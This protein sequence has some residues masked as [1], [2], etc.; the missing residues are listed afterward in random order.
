MLSAAGHVQKKMPS[1]PQ[2]ERDPLERIW[3]LLCPTGDFEKRSNA[4]MGSNSDASMGLNLMA[5]LLHMHESIAQGA[6][7]PLHVPIHIRVNYDYRAHC[8]LDL[9][10][11][12]H[13]RDISRLFSKN[14]ETE[15]VNITIFLELI[16]V[17]D[18]DGL[19]KLPAIFRSIFSKKGKFDG[20]RLIQLE[21]LSN[22]L[23]TF[24]YKFLDHYLI[25]PAAYLLDTMN[26]FALIIQLAQQKPH[27]IFEM[28]ISKLSGLAV[29]TCLA[30]FLMSIIDIDPQWEERTAR[31]LYQSFENCYVVPHRDGLTPRR[32]S[33]R[34]IV[35]FICLHDLHKSCLFLEPIYAL[36]NLVFPKA[37]WEDSWNCRRLGRD[38]YLEVI[39]Q[40]DKIQQ[41]RKAILACARGCRIDTWRLA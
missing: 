33:A 7:L 31:E 21:D 17:A 15:A 5:Q 38:L 26:C 34:V 22:L 24:V 37:E 1:F 14:R 16:I 23:A 40:V 32:R 41:T 18:D 27:Q 29:P 8:A 30:L 3:N 6:R 10:D 13:E 19:K 36:A 28:V 2:L 12:K 39:R 9:W 20:F 4:S 25:D 11:R 35:D